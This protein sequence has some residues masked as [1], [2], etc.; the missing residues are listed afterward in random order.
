MQL[1]MNHIILSYM[2][3]RPQRKLLWFSWFSLNHACFPMN[4]DHVDQQYKST[5]CYSKSFTTNTYFLLK[6][7]KFSCKWYIKLAVSVFY[8]L[9]S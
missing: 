9:L 5:E 4:H 7:Q 8:N 6:M 1:K 2:G 3:K